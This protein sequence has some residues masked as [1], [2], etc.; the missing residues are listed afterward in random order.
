MY[1]IHKNLS[2]KMITGLTFILLDTLSSLFILLPTV[3]FVKD[4][5]HQYLRGAK[6]NVHV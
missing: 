1:N 5:Y 6:Y 3:N 2:S 4:I